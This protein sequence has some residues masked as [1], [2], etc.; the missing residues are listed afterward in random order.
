LSYGPES[1]VLLNFVAIQLAAMIR[2]YD[3]ITTNRR[4]SAFAWGFWPRMTPITS[5]ARRC[6]VGSTWE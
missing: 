3:L 1:L 4:H 6:I 2:H 5:A